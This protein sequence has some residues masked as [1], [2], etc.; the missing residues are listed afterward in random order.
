MAENPFD[1]KNAGL[2]GALGGTSRGLLDL[3]PTGVPTPPASPS[4]NALYGLLGDRAPPTVET[5]PYSS[6]FRL[7]GIFG[8]LASCQPPPVLPV[9]TLAQVI[10][11]QAPFFAPP[12]SPARPFGF[13]CR[14]RSTT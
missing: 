11:S 12:L 5:N 6:P 13:T 3:I 1:P 10:A 14:Y 8:T 4:T 7:A 9:N 2:L